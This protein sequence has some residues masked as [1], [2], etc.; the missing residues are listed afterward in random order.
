LLFFLGD[1]FY[2]TGLNVPE[3][4]VVSTINAC[5][6]PFSP[7]FER[8]GPE[9][10][11]AVPGN[12]DYYC[13]MLGPIPYGRCIQGN[14]RENAITSWTFHMIMPS[15]IRR[16]THPASTDSVEFVFFDSALLLATERSMWST[17]LDSLERLLR[18]SS[19]SRGIRW[20]IVV[21]HHSPFSVGEHGGWR[22]WS[23]REKRVQ[24]LGNCWSDGMDPKKYVEQ[25]IS[26]QDN[27]AGDYRAYVDSLEARIGRSRA[28][29]QLMLTGHD[30]S[31]Q[32]LANVRTGSGTATRTYI[33]SGA[34]SKTA[35]VR[36]SFPPHVWTHPVIANNGE[37]A[38]GYVVG[39]FVDDHLD[40]RFIDPRTDQTLDMGGRT[41]FRVAVTGR[42]E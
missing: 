25:T 21:A 38:P 7:A 37:S 32:L 17:C 28:L 41:E 5:L 36:S 18:R 3:D 20:R 10:V 12:H 35:T 13:G 1:N 4:D 33:V 19:S 39:S 6:E 22:H 26:S 23:D 2:P 34:G 31:L 24:Y 27:C 14:I 8:L 15:S 42:L 29:V 9:N 11:H 16:P 30:H 40:L